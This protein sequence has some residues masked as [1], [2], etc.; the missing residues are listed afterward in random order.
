MVDGLAA[1]KIRVPVDWRG[2]GFKDAGEDI[3]TFKVGCLEGNVTPV[4]SLLASASL[5]AARTVADPAGNHKVVKSRQQARDDAAVAMGARREPR[6][7]TA[8]AE[9]PAPVEPHLAGQVSRHHAALSSREWAR[10]RLQALDRDEHRCRTL[11]T[12]DEPSGLS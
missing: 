2:Q 6:A 8:P 1:T 3:R 11:P 10:V 5:D 4:D 12:E 9:A 7:E